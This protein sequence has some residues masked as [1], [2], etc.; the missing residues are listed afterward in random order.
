[1]DFN[2]EW[3]AGRLILSTHITQHVYI[4][5]NS[6]Q[7]AAVS[8]QSHISDAL[9]RACM[10][11][12]MQVCNPPNHLKAYSYAVNT[13]FVCERHSMEAPSLDLTRIKQDL[14]EANR[15][16]ALKKFESASDLLASA[17]ES[18]YVSL[19]SF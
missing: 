2:L 14:D 12:K 10:Q 16:L 8:S 13:R 5:P 17:L 1:M 15:L 11:I 18:L 7:C 19:G 6:D 3:G 4:N 9:Q